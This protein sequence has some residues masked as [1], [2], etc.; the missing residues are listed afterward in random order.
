MNFLFYENFRVK[1]GWQDSSAMQQPTRIN[2]NIF[3]YGIYNSQ[4]REKR[5]NGIKEEWIHLSKKFN[6]E[7]ARL[8]C[9]LNFSKKPLN[10]NQMK[11]LFILNILQERE[12]KIFQGIRKRQLIE[13]KE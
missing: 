13:K 12:T 8:K 11:I 3:G 6:Q 7:C 10:N 1:E 2:E 4:D 5:W 9:I